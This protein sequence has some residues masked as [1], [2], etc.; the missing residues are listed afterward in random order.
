MAQSVWLQMAQGALLGVLEIG[1]IDSVL[2]SAGRCTDC[3]VHVVL[4]HF[5]CVTV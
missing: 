3:I 5:V 2:K 1:Q 4:I